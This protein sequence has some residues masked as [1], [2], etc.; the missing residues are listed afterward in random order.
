MREHPYVRQSRREIEHSFWAGFQRAV[1][2]MFLFSGLIL[3][4]LY[5]NAWLN[6]G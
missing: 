4:L 6:G 2:R 3:I 5:I 1:W